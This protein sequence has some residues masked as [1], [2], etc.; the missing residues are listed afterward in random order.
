MVTP[1]FAQTT[2][3]PR[4]CA[5]S[6][7]RCDICDEDMW[8]GFDVARCKDACGLGA[9]FSLTLYAQIGVFQF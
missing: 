7:Y 8:H 1:N 6:K 9:Q 3:S 5:M 4:G 2:T